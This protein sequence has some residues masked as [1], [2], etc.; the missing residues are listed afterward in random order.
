MQAL[1]TICSKWTKACRTHCLNI[2]HSTVLLNA[3]MSACVSLCVCVESLFPLYC[4]Y[5]LRAI[6]IECTL[7]RFQNCFNI[8]FDSF[9][10]INEELKFTTVGTL[11][12][13][14]LKT[15]V[16]FDVSKTVHI[17][18]EFFDVANMKSEF[19]IGQISAFIR[20]SSIKSINHPINGKHFELQLPSGNVHCV[21]HENIS[22]KINRIINSSSGPCKDPPFTQIFNYFTSK[23]AENLLHL[24]ATFVNNDLSCFIAFI[25][26]S[27]HRTSSTLTI[28]DNKRT[29][30]FCLMCAVC[31]IRTNAIASFPVLLNILNSQRHFVASNIN[32]II[33]QKLPIRKHF[34]Y[35]TELV[36]FIRSFDG[37]K[38]P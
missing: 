2:N 29:T 12:R 31:V 34:Q 9:I 27:A 1:Q 19:A 30:E 21:Q 20:L 4:T 28:H 25:T 11:T 35:F 10:N 5:C 3:S 13:S 18:N 32:L 37:L 14:I 6:S 7:F 8:L 23:I 33:C 26:S 22:D 36:Q 38:L 24:C 15:C 17:E 16:H